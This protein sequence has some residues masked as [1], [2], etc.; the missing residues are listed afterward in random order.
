MVVCEE[1]G[2]EKVQTITWVEI[3]SQKVFDTALS[4][5]CD[6]QDNWCPDCNSNCPVT[7]KEIYD[8]RFKE[9]E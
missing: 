5:S 2:C 1:C 6:E 9:E 7:D 8:K 3:N 4:Q